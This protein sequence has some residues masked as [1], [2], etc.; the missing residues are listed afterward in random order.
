V[1]VLRRATKEVE[2]IFAIEEMN[3]ARTLARDIALLAGSLGNLVQM[4][5]AGRVAAQNFECPLFTVGVARS[6]L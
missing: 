3:H 2:G 1:S 5:V 6:D 4:Y